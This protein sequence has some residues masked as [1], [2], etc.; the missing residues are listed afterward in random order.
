M[1]IQTSAVGYSLHYEKHKEEI[2]E[3]HRYVNGTVEVELKNGDPLVKFEKHGNR[4]L[5]WYWEKT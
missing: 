4:R 2:G 5:Y 1:W 3:V